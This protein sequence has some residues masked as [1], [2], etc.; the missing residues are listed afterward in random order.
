M[1][2]DAQFGDNCDDGT[3][4]VKNDGPGEKS[5]DE[6]HAN[7]LGVLHVNQRKQDGCLESGK[8]TTLGNNFR[9]RLQ[10]GRLTYQQTDVGSIEVG[11]LDKPAAITTRYW[12][13]TGVNGVVWTTKEHTKAGLGLNIRLRKCRQRRLA[14]KSERFD[15][16]AIRHRFGK[17]GSIVFY[18]QEDWENDFRR[19]FTGKR[20]D[21]GSSRRLVW[22]LAK[23]LY[24][25]PEVVVARDVGDF[26]FIVSV[27]NVVMEVGEREYLV[28]LEQQV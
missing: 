25:L 4:K 1:G 24:G 16:A 19:S 13:W 21:R 15:L 23:V 20:D 5:V 27:F 8:Y 28:N 12:F 17:T 3:E 11:W 26:I 9:W 6:S 22:P 7:W 14:A 18:V 2:I 10:F